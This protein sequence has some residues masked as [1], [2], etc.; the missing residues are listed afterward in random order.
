MTAVR[1][2]LTLARLSGVAVLLLGV[3]FWAGQALA[4]VTLHMALGVILVLAL[5]TLAGLAFRAGVDRATVAIAV[6]WG[7][8]LPILGVVQLTLPPGG[9]Y[10]FVRV[11]HLVVG[12][13]AIAQSESLAGRIR[14][15]GAGASRGSAPSQ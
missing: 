14:R 2:T 7:F 12:L 4:F 11:L 9:G 8:V 3:L 13:G 10:G 15:S 5:W 6:A 1:V